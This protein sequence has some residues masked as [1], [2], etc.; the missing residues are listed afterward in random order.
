MKI[1]VACIVVLYNPG[2]DVFDNIQCCAD[3]VGVVFIIDNSS[4]PDDNLVER[5]KKQKNLFYIKNER[6]LGLA[7]ALNMGAAKAIERGCDYL[8][9]MDQDSRPAPD[10][11]AR[12][13]DCLETFEPTTVGIVSPCHVIRN[14]PRQER[15]GCREV[16][17]AMTSGNLL[18]LEVYQ[19]VGPFL[20]ELFIDYIDHEY[21]LRLHRQGFKVIEAPAALLEHGLGNTVTRDFGIKRFSVTNHHPFR[22][23]FMTRN[24][25]YVMNTYKEEF[26]G[27]YRQ[28][29]RA[30]FDELAGILFFERQKLPKFRMVLKGYLDYKRG[31]TGG[32][33]AS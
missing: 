7:R 27:Y 26:Q 24:R 19:K 20:D 32:E 10:M 23:Y 15:V 11:V 21:C 8:L 6:N 29:L 28:Q 1:K 13:M 22:R 30:F 17:V 25:F 5:I 2:E 18:N 9:T 14:M 3:Q 33:I 4:T 31:V 12:M 16:L